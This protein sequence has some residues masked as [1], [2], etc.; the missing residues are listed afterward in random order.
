MPANDGTA[1]VLRTDNLRRSM[2]VSGVMQTSI[3]RLEINT[4]ASRAYRVSLVSAFITAIPDRV[5]GVSRN[6]AGAAPPS[7]YF[8]CY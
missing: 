6:C 3:L 2:K 5:I 8:D 4:R 7:S 1:P